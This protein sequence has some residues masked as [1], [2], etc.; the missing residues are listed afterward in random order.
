LAI[1]SKFSNF[2]VR[3]EKGKPPEIESSR[4]SISTSFH[5]VRILPNNDHLSKNSTNF[6]KKSIRGK[7]TSVRELY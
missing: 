6:L 7:A 1:T 3:E 2:I 4:I 5:K